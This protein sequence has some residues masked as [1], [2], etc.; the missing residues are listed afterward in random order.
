[1]TLRPLLAAPIAALVAVSLAPHP[2]AAPPLVLAAT[3]SQVIRTHLAGYLSGSTSALRSSAVD[4]SG[5]GAVFRQGDSTV[6]Q[7]AST[8]KLF[9]TLAGLKGLG[10]STR[11][12]TDARSAATPVGGVLPGDLY[13]VAGGDP[14]LSSAQL[15]QLAAGVRSKGITR[16]GGHLVVDDYRYDAVRRAPGW[17][18]AFVPEDSGPLSAFALDRNQWRKDANYLA[19]PGLPNLARFRELLV[20][21]GVSVST[22]LV[23]RHAPGGM[24]LL[25]RKVSPTVQDMVRL[26][27]KDSFNFG[28]ELMLKELGYRLK[29][30]GSTAAGAAAVQTV[31]TPL[32][33][34]TTT[35]Y[36]GS[37]LSANDRQ[38]A[39]GELSLL[40]G[41][42]RAGLYG[43]LRAALPIACRDGTLEHRLCGTAAAGRA[44]AKTGTLPGVH[45]L[46]GWTTTADGHLV[47]FSFLLT[48]VSDAT[49][50]RAAIDACVAYLSGVRVS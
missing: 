17:K 39:S 24:A 2:A 35:M 21:H 37:G 25:G 10:A 6:V 50:A 29:G 30:V 45:A 11:L 1:M 15:D 34:T 16:I 32:K 49:R 31:L 19:D 7:P 40:L 26:I 48:R 28:A 23:R 12:S 9:T 41:A 44:S 42:Q 20:R 27:D 33:I 4:I 5:V 38:A 36:D 13:L 8:Q 3:S 22:S 46:T 47:R 43:P 14:F 18:T